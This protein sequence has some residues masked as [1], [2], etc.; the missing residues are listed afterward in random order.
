MQIR[1]TSITRHTVLV[2][3]LAFATITTALGQATPQE[4]PN[5]PTPV[6]GDYKVKNFEFVSKETLPELSLHYATLGTPHKGKVGKT[7]TAVLIM[8]GTRGCMAT[9]PIPAFSRSRFRPLPH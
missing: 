9:F 3:F 6:E 1:N 5:Y 7:D 8:H 4:K 2:L